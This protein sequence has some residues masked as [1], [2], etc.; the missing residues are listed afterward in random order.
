MGVR[1]FQTMMAIPPDPNN[2]A[3]D[4]LRFTVGAQLR[5]ARVVRDE[6]IGAIADYLR[7]KPEYLFAVEQERHDQLPPLAYALGFV[8]S[9]A[10]YLG[11]DGAALREAYRQEM[12]NKLTPQ[13]CMPQPLT[14]AHSPPWP[15]ILGALLAALLI[16]T[17]WQQLNRPTGL[18]L[19][20]LEPPRQSSIGK[21]SRPLPNVTATPATPVVSPAPLTLAPLI[22][23]AIEP[24]TPSRPP[25]QA[26]QQAKTV[27][28]VPLPV[29]EQD[30]KR[31]EADLATQPPA[32]AVPVAAST[33]RR[34]GDTSRATRRVIYAEATAR[35]TIRNAQ[36]RLIFSRMLQPGDTYQVPDRPGLWLSSDRPDA[37]T[38]VQD[39]KNALKPGGPGSETFGLTLDE[40]GKENP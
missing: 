25:Q 15:I 1:N 28:V 6:S 35:V 26:T 31:T 22:L 7:I 23:R 17:L 21:S 30:G 39:G 12:L 32:V 5:R 27:P 3:D 40:P 16:Y 2:P 14:E 29:D 8:H 38:I 9:Y 11:L 33:G 34:L 10:T 20:P 18:P 24:F 13:L 19:P 36:Q 4:G 37:L